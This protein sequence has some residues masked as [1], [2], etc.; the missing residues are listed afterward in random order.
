VINKN[1]FTL[2]SSVTIN[3]RSGKAYEN[4]NLKL[5]AGDVQTHRNLMGRNDS[6]IVT[7]ESALMSRQAAPPTF[8][9]REFAD[10]RIYTL[11][12][13]VDIDNNQEKQ[14]SLYPLKSVKYVKKYEYQIGSTITDVFMTFKNS[15]ANGL[16][17]PLP[18]GNINFYEIDDKDGNSLAWQLFK[19]LL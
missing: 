15:I 16:G 17:V 5:I 19:T 13:K 14:L 6:I 4:V 12:Q 11:D 7:K 1:D 8:E 18:R 3:N 10:F 9:E 2:N